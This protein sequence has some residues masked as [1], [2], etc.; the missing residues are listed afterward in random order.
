[1]N[2]EQ[3]SVLGVSMESATTYAETVVTVTHEHGLHAR[4]ADLFVRC[5]NTFKSTISAA[6]E[7]RNA[8]KKANAKSILGVLSIGVRG[9]DQV[10]ISANGADCEE[11]ILA[12][13]RLIESNFAEA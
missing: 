12:L 8:A 13:S 2:I 7:T 1:M 6:N 5:A 11:A 9:G 10:R 4:P 3:T